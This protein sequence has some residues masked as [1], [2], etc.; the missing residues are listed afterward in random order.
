[1]LLCTQRMNLRPLGFVIFPIALLLA[2]APAGANPIIVTS[3]NSSFNVVPFPNHND[4]FNDQQTGGNGHASQDIVGDASNPG[5]LTAFDGTYVYYRVRL[6]ATDKKDEYSGVFWIGIDG[7]GDGK[8][9]L[10]LGVNNSGSL[11]EIELRAPGTG[12]NNSPNTTTI[13]NVLAANKIQENSTNYN[14]QS[15]NTTLQPGITNTD[16]NAKGGIDAFLTIQIPFFGLPGTPTLQ[17]AMAS[18][19]GIAIT[20]NTALSYVIATSTNGNSLNQDIGGINDKT[21]NLARTYAELGAITPLLYVSGR[22]YVPPL[23]VPEPAS[24]TLAAL[25][26]ALLSVQRF[27]RRRP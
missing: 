24:L 2:A 8:L 16:L 26:L 9:D 1:M 27:R 11:T 19:G 13:A 14:Y 21:A 4:F 3:P 17:G 18:L 6:G 5:F 23:P 22:L 12:L 7:N 20:S 10:F 15:V 25:G